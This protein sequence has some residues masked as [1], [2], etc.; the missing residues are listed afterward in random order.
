[1]SLIRRRSLIK[2]GGVLAGAMSI[3]G[4]TAAASASSRATFFTKVVN[5]SAED[6]VNETSAS[7]T[8]T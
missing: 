8:S 1:M 2:A 6:H 7:S 4:P 3:G 5:S